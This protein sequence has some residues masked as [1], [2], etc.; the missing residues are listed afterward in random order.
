ME[1]KPNRYP[2]M[3]AVVVMAF[4]CAG[5]VSAATVTQSTTYQGKLTDAAGNPLT[6]TYSVKF[7]LW[8][9]ATGGTELIQ[10]YQTVTA[11]NGLFTTPVSFPPYRFDGSALWLGVTVGTDP[12]MTPGRRSGRCRMP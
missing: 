3:A 12:E 9:A 1:R 11:V 10:N 8:D 7:S 2:E 4:L 6:G 5:I